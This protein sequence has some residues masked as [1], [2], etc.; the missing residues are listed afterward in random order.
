VAV[1]SSQ[2]EAA[3]SIGATRW[4]VIRLGVLRYGRSGI[5]GA[6]ILGL[7]RAVGETMAVT[8]V[9]GG[10][11]GPYV[12]P[13]SLLKGG[14]TLSSLIATEFSE[15]SGL[16]LS[17]LF[18]LGLV[19]FLFALVINVLARLMVWRVFKVTGGSVE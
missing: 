12:I 17:A 14:V 1:P 16:H 7:G 2:R 13:T 8:M 4:E 15:A 11:P 18:G 3:Y 5:F 6:A 10:T 19:L 9:I